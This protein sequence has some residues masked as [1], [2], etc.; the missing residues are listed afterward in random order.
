MYIVVISQGSSSVSSGYLGCY[1]R[2]GYAILCLVLGVF[3]EVF[4]LVDGGQNVIE[5][6][7]R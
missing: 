2:F 3:G 6:D 7:Q 4:R 1:Q 5:D